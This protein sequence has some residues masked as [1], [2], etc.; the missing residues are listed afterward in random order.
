MCHGVQK[1]HIHRGARPYKTHVTVKKVFPSGPT[2][3]QKF[4]AVQDCS[5]LEKKILAAKEWKLAERFGR[6]SLYVVIT[7]LQA[8]PSLKSY[9]SSYILI[10]KL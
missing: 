4:R 10:F 5:T 9:I 2:V 1:D 8:R 6:V 3:P 7:A